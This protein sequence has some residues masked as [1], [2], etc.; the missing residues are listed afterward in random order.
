[1][2]VLIPVADGSEEMETVI[3]ADVFRRVPWEVTLAGLKPGPITASRGV[4]LIPDAAWPDVRV[5]DYGLLVIPGGLEGVRA[6]AG[7]RRVLEAVRVFAASGK[8]VA[9]ICAGP[10]VLQ[11]AGILDARAAT[12]HPGVADE[13]TRARRLDTRVVT[14]G[15]LITS[16][17]PGTALEF[18]LAVVAAA[19]GPGRAAGLARD[20][21]CT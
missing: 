10:L 6:M 1:M 2:K 12:C 5:E 11:A 16:Q 3:A 20:L 4:R 8:W 19:A 15:R 17:G 7:D 21:V 9:A 13:L 18:A 14:D